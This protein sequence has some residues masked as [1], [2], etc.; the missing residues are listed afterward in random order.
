MPRRDDFIRPR[1]NPKFCSIALFAAF[2]RCCPRARPGSPP[3][4]RQTL[5]R[6]ESRRA[7]RP[8]TTSCRLFVFRR[9]TAVRQSRAPRPLPPLIVI[10]N[11]TP[12]VPRR[13]LS[14]SRVAS[15]PPPLTP[16]HCHPEPHPVCA[17][18]PPVGEPFRLRLAVRG[19]CVPRGRAP[20]SPARRAWENGGAGRDLLF[21]STPP[22]S[23]ASSSFAT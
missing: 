15:A 5:S 20:R 8:F 1:F 22:A 23:S 18:T 6:R 11:P 4:A 7:N 19:V 14:G 17:P 12:F 2:P 13:L 10:P 16:S 9:P 21:L 3:L